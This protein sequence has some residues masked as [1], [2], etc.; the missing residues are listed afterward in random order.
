MYPILAPIGGFHWD[1]LVDKF[2][3]LLENKMATLGFAPF[4][5][6]KGIDE[7]PL[8]IREQ[9]IRQLELSGKVCKC[10][11]PEP[12]IPSK[13]ILSSAIWSAHSACLHSSNKHRSY[14]R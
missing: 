1:F 13:H 10:G 7:D 11:D 6:T 4:P 12:I 2:T 5:S 3:S 14:E 8:A 9:R